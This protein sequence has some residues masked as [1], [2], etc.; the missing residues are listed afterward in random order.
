MKSGLVGVLVAGALA[1]GAIHAQDSQDVLGRAMKDELARSMAELRLDTF[2]KPY[3]ISYRVEETEGNNATAVLGSLLRSADTH[4]RRLE[5]EVRV[6]DYQFDNTNYWDRFAGPAAMMSMFAGSTTLPLDDNY[7]EFRRQL[8]L[9]T[10]ALYKQAITMLSAKRAALETQNRYDSLGDFTR[11]PVLTLSDEIPAPRHQ[12]ADV[13]SLVQRLSGVFRDLPEIQTSGV[14]WSTGVIHTRF[15]NSEGTSFTRVAPWSTLRIIATTQAPDGMPLEENWSGH[16]PAPPVLANIDPF[17]KRARDLGQ[18]LIDLRRARVAEV[19]NGPVLFEGEAAGEVFNRFLGP[20]LVAFR[21]PVTNGAILSALA[22]QSFVDLIGSRVLPPTFTVVDNPTVIT[23]DGQYI[24]GYRV[25]DEGVAGRATQLVDHGVLK[26]L[27]TTRVPVRGLSHSTGNRM[28]RAAVVS[29]LFF[30]VDSGATEGELKKQ[31]VRLAATDGKPYGILVR[32]LLS[33]P[34]RVAVVYKVFPDGR[35]ELV[36]N[37]NISGITPTSFKNIVAASKSLTVYEGPFFA[38][39]GPTGMAGTGLSWSATYVA[40][41]VLFNDVEI[42]PYA[43][44][45]PKLPAISPPH[46]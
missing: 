46:D 14:T 33:V 9:A 19:Y 3:F 2:P 35:E 8:W 32:Q 45:V 12:R 18:R 22:G 23:Y 42:R 44:A 29:N 26:T 4:V 37:A 28:G 15:L 24:G 40:P 7:Q 25:D 31:L 1:P 11:E 6:G 13:E 20:Q 39:S 10:D 36:R 34:V 27:L 38:L 43:G 30:T 17:L 16:G 41:S 21:M 5:V